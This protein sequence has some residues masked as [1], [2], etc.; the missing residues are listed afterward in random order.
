MVFY[1]DL[2][3]LLNFVID[4]FLLLATARFLHLPVKKGRFAIG[5]TLGAMYTIVYF[6]PELGFFHIFI[7]KIIFSVIMV[8]SAFGY[9]HFIAF[10]RS[11]STFYFVSFVTGGGVFALQYF[12]QINHDVING[13]YVSRSTNPLIVLLLIFIG[14]IGIWFFSGKTFQAMERKR[15]IHQ[16]IIDIEIYMFDAIIQCKGLVDTGNQLY[17]PI[18]R[19]PVMILEAKQLSILPEFYMGLYQNGEFQLEKY[20]QLSDQVESKWLTR[21]QLIPF[22]SVGK[23]MEFIL[24]LRPDKV[25]IQT[26]EQKDLFQSKVLVGLDFGQLSNDQAYQAIIHPDLLTG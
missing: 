13:I 20:H 3:I 10:I 24:A 19:K 12:F 15:N 22:R 26:E 11:I 2:I 5:A 23:N 17:D 9:S 16:H 8:I 21:T 1:L 25:V 14:F 7:T 6:V 4:Y 18:S